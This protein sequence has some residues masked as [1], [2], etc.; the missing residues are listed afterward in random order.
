MVKIRI[1]NL[2][3]F[4]ARLS[5]GV[6]NLSRATFNEI[7]K[8]AIKFYSGLAD[9]VARSNEFQLL[10]SDPDLRGK[11]GLAKPALKF[12][13]DT[14]ANDL[15]KELRKFKVKTATSTRGRRLT[16]TFPSI[17]RLEKKLTH[18]FTRLKDGRTIRG[19]RMSWFRWWEFGD[20]GEISSLTVLKRTVTKLGGTTSAGRQ[21]SRAQLLQILKEKSRSGSAIQLKKQSPD[22]N[23]R[24]D[25]ASLIRRTYGNF[26]RVFPA[27]MGK[28]LKKII[29][30]NGGRAE[31]FFARGV[32]R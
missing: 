13:S 21:K 32:I 11:L 7:K 5:A 9:N 26:A 8:D 27:R 24:I 29:A 2:N 4:E 3:E 31:K 15:I 14:D 10:Q 19:P 25:G 12:A 28:T 22:A 17:S 1:S 20:R 30:R 6:K 18:N 16:I 23:S